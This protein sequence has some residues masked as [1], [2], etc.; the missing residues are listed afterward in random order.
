[1]RALSGQV[2]KT[3]TLEARSGWPVT[4]A[5]LAGSWSCHRGRGRKSGGYGANSAGWWAAIAVGK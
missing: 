1:M 4:A 5:G 2:L 3:P